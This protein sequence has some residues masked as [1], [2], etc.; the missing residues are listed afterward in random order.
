MIGDDTVYTSHKLLAYGD[1]LKEIIEKN[2]LIGREVETLDTLNNRI[3]IERPKEIIITPIMMRRS[4]PENRKSILTHKV[5]FDIGES[6]PTKAY[7]KEFKE[8]AELLVNNKQLGVIIT[9][10]ADSKGTITHNKILSQMRAITVLEKLDKLGINLNKAII[11][12]KGEDETKKEDTEEDRAYN[13]R[14]EMKV[15]ELIINEY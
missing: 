15:F 2:D 3:I 9:G 5:F 8:I 12:A 13:R 4:D 10:F 7:K 14:V 11:L 6:E 1:R